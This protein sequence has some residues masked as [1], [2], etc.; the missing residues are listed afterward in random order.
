MQTRSSVVC[1]ASPALN[2]VS[3]L[4]ARA[5]YAIWASRPRAYVRTSPQRIRLVSPLR[6]CGSS[7]SL[8]TFHLEPIAPANMP[9]HSVIFLFGTVTGHVLRAN[10]G[11]AELRVCGQRI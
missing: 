7:T 5:V 1:S 2:L 9:H 3:H 10:I 8:A 11:L 6:L 4:V